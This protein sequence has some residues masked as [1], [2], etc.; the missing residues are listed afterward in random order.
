MSSIGLSILLHETEHP[1][2]PGHPENCERLRLIAGELSA[3]TDFAP[4]DGPPV[5][6]DQLYRVHHRDYIDRLIR[7]VS[8]GSGNVDADTYYGPDSVQAARIVSGNALKAVDMAF[9]NGPRVAF[10][11]GRPPGHHAEA[12][13]GMGF[14]LVNH[15]A[16]AAQYA[17]DEYHLKRVAI[18]DFDVHHGNGTQ[19][20]FYDRADVLYVSTHQHPFYPG[21]GA[22]S[23]RGASDGE[24][25]TINYPLPPGMDDSTYCGLMNDEVVPALSDFN[26]EY[27][28][29]SAGFDGHGLDPL[30]GF[31]L[32]GRTYHHIATSLVRVAEEK[33]HGRIL[34]LL[35]GGYEDRGNLDA[36]SS[37]ISGLEQ[38]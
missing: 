23:E 34:A 31:H 3:R 35:E 22:A 11:L 24:G 38:S 8:Q 28:V 12:G 9:G 21:T 4:L 36:I 10:I 33:C 1:P 26:P 32:T 29:V 2:P 15:A 17:I 20:I 37:F 5:D 19:D 16:V 6:L 25:Y 18:F 30:G 27:I 14:C 13:R 7:L